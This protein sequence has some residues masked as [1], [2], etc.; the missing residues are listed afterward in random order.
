MLAGHEVTRG[1]Q[2]WLE[3]EYL[4]L[5][6]RAGLRRP[7]TQQVLSRARDRLVRVDCRFAGT[8]VVVELLGYRFHRSRGQMSGDATR[9]N[10][11]LADGFA[12]YQFTYGQ[13]VSEADYVVATT[14]NALSAAAA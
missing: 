14:R 7:A 8:N 11:L 1:G 13:I 2:S 6:D 12:P 10:A 9:Y 5:L 3:R 4:R